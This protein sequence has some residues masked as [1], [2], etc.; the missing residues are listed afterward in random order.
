MVAQPITVVLLAR[1][2]GYPLTEGCIV[3][4]IILY[5]VTGAFWLRS[6]GCCP[7]RNRFDGGEITGLLDLVDQDRQHAIEPIALHL[8]QLIDRAGGDLL[9]SS[10]P[11]YRAGTLLEV[12]VYPVSPK[13]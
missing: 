9:Q 11:R 13:N 12:G 7:D 8:T 6:Y 2:V 3:W 1:T 10:F 5:V 4:S